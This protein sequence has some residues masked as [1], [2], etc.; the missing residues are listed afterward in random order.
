ML[1]YFSFLLFLTAPSR[2]PSPHAFLLPGQTGIVR[3]HCHF[4]AGVLSQAQLEQRLVEEIRSSQRYALSQLT[5]YCIA[6][7]QSLKP[8]QGG[9]SLWSF[10]AN[11]LE[12]TYLEGEAFYTKQPKIRPKPT[13]Y[14][15]HCPADVVPS[16]FEA[17]ARRH[18]P[19]E[20]CCHLAGAELLGRRSF[21]PSVT[22]QTSALEAGASFAILCR[23]SCQR[24]S[25]RWTHFQGLSTLV[26]HI[27]NV[28]PQNFNFKFRCIIFKTQFT[29]LLV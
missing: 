18:I 24:K 13:H 21:L 15:L 1:L 19:L 26:T 12:L 17:K 5:K 8:R 29:H 6:P 2:S 7:L 3:G 16:K 4:L 14:V 25:T 27:T 20:L 9:T 11:E 10:A 23:H 28:L 22:V